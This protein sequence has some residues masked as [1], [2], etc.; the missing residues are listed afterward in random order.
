MKH[1]CKFK[2]VIKT[3]ECVVDICEICKRKEYYPKN[4]K[5]QIDN[6]KYNKDHERDLLQPNNPK[7]KQYY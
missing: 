1:L 4:K 5:G 7:F 2:T 6:I 3:N